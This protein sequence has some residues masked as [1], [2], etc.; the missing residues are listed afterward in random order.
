MTSG[1]GVIGY[2]VAVS[3]LEAGHKDVRVGIWKGDRD[4]GNPA[5]FGEQC[6]KVLE[7]KG[8][9]IV[10]FD[11]KHVEDYTNVLNDVKTVFCNM[12]HIE[13]WADYFFKFLEECKVR[14]VEHFVKTSFLRQTKANLG[15]AEVARSYREHV[16][17]VEFH[18]RCDDILEQAPSSSRISYTILCT[19]HLMS[20]PLIFQGKL[21]REEHKFVSASYGMGVN[22]VSPNDVADAAV[23][24]LLNQKPYRN[25][26]YNLTGKEP[27]TDA[28]VVKVLSKR[29][30]K[31]I[32]HIE[33]GYHAYKRDVQ[34]RGLPDFMAKD[35]ALFE[36]MKA[37]GMDELTVSYT[38]DLQKIIGK[39]PE[40]I[41]DYLE[42]T[43]AM[44]PGMTFP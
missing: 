14:K 44:R 43:S 35:A 4:D 31:R 13:G 7:S 38:K 26:V 1:T 23:V 24:V 10:D 11:W 19:S 18:G 12:P 25:K 17:F 21:L 32:E 41:E 15:I 30:G 34:Q 20:T 9:E 16:P 37:M 33:L 40:T 28:H 36:R 8:A 29:Y 3:L 2:R 27:T 5:S 42:H 6:A 39:E 22:Y